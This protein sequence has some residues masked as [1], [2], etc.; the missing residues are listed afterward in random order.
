MSILQFPS[1]AP[2]A[3][4]QQVRDLA[5]TEAALDWVPDEFGVD[6]SGFY[7]ASDDDWSMMEARFARYGLRVHRNAPLESYKNGM[8]YLGQFLSKIGY[9]REHPYHYKLFTSDWTPEEHA[10]LRAVSEA[11]LNSA[12]EV[13]PRTRFAG[14]IGRKM[15]THEGCALNTA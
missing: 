1:R 13:L 11:D 3:L 15:R 8:R 5:K 12:F 14:E 2:A 6:E 9:F 7:A 10:Y 4:S